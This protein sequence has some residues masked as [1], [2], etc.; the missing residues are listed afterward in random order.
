M[1]ISFG[2]SIHKFAINKTEIIL[3][4]II[5]LYLKRQLFHIR[6]AWDRIVGVDAFIVYTISLLLGI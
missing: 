4:Y 1:K 2:F 6:L 5:I 3:F